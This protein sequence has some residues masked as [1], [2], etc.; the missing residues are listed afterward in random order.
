MNTYQSS[1]FV[2][3]DNGYWIS[4]PK[5]SSFSPVFESTFDQ[6]LIWEVIF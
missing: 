4:D 6:A 5:D 2:E 1:L 3:K